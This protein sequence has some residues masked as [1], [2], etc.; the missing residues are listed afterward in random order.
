MR[1]RATKLL[2]D[3][4]P[5]PAESED[6]LYLT[7]RS[8]ELEPEKPLPVMVW[9]HGGDHQDGS[10]ID[11]YYTANTLAKR[12]VVTVAINYRLG[13]FGYFAHPE[14]CDESEHGVAS[15]YGTLDQ[16]AALEWVR[17]N[18]A[19]FG[20][21]PDNVTIFGESAGGESVLHMMTSP[22]ARGLFHRA[23][24]QSPANAG[25]MQHLR[26]PFL[27]SNSGLDVG[28]AVAQALGAGAEEQVAHLRSLPATELN[29]G[30]IEHGPT[31]GFYPQIDGHV[32][33]VSPLVCFA[34]GEQAK[35]PLVIGS[36][37]DE[38]SALVEW[39]F[40]GPMIEYRDLDPPEDGVLPEV[41]DAFGDDFAEL[42]E[43][44]PGLDR[45]DRRA[46]ADFCGDHLFGA[47]AYF[48]ATSHRLSGC[49]TWLYHFTRT[50]PSPSQRLGAYHAAELPFV[51]GSSLPIFSMT[52]DD[53]A[54]SREMTR[55]WTNLARSGNPNPGRVEWPPFD[56]ADPH[57]LRLDH[58]VEF[59]QVD[60]QEQ[61]RI[62]NA[63]TQRLIA[64]MR[65]A[66]ARG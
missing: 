62:F 65:A 48:Y 44:Y 9:I 24:A 52:D 4:A 38:A 20:G 3:K 23:I 5:R 47:P 46:E 28:V 11:P 49:P 35:V 50:P 53:R 51:H 29:A 60:R 30:A 7:V 36:N 2:L 33:P 14:L 57:W 1:T 8:P 12:H 59:V 19:A 15:N 6:C 22:L 21:D 63:R 26:V 45:Q 34:D 55:Y 42:V 54:L 10:H 61:Y 16:I 13:V 17:D 41:V 39:I 18:I 58:Q 40:A 66:I 27:A 37:A 31:G 56:P 32:L 64:D 43:L 25:Q